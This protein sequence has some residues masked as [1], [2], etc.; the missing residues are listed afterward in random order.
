MHL[1][2]DAVYGFP[3]SYTILP[4][5]ANDSPQLPKLIRKAE[6][7]HPWLEME[8]A[9]ADKGYDALKNFKFLDDRMIDP[10]I[11]IRDTYKHGDL[12]D[13]RGRPICMGNKPM[14]YVSTDPDQGHLFRCN[15]EGCH[16]KNQLAFSLYCADTCYEQPEGELL[17]KVGRVARASQEF[18]DLYRHRQTIE[19]F[20]RSLKHSR[21]LDQHRYRSFT[22]VKLHAALALLTYVATMLNKVLC[23]RIQSMRQMRVRTPKPVL[24][25][26]RHGI[27]AVSN[28]ND[29]TRPILEVNFLT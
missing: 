23:G 14:E 4:A 15:P 27:P 24:D 17:R 9:T 6:Q 3:L 29:S 5:N 13:A 20:F 12:Y 8:Y 25:V 18:K 7:E 19:R 1:V 10:I 26:G 2:C 22:K 21:L 11:L 16:L 28:D